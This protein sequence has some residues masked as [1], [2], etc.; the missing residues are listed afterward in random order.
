MNEYK[1][2][3]CGAT[4]RYQAGCHICGTAFEWVPF[5]HGSIRD[6]KNVTEGFSGDTYTEVY[7][8]KR[9]DK[10]IDLLYVDRIIYNGI[11]SII[12]EDRLKES[13]ISEFIPEL[14]K[15]ATFHT[16]YS[17][18]EE[19]TNVRAILRVIKNENGGIL[20]WPK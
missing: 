2:P 1:C 19:H 17:D 10:R 20:E 3:N 12:N 13:L 18:I 8:N 4:V 11:A 14:V 5:P 9:Y 6:Y 16:C 15:R 7:D